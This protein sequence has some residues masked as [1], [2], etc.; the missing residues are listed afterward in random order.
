MAVYLDHNATAPLRAVALEAMQRVLARAAG[1]PS[2]VHRFGRAMRAVIEDARVQVAALAGAAP[3]G[4][5]FTSGGTEAN[6][7][8]ILGSARRRILASAIEHPS[9]LK[10]AD[11]IE[12]VP[13]DADG[14]VDLEV[15]ET[16][17]AARSDPA[18]VSVM[19]ANNETGVLQPVAEVA[20]IAH[21]HGA[22]VHCDAVQAA[23]RLPLDIQAL[24]AD[25]LTL[26]AHKLGGPP[27]VGAV[28]ISGGAGPTAV[29]RGGAQERGL[30]AGTE[31]VPGIAGFGAAAAAAAA[32]VGDRGESRRLTALRDRLEAGVR[33]LCPAA[34]ILGGAVPRLPNT[35]CVTMPGVAGETQV[36][37]FDLEG[38]AVSAGA[39]CSSGKIGR[40]HV[41][42]AMGV[43]PADAASAIRVSLGWTTGD[44]DVERFLA[45]WRQ[46]D[47]RAA[48]GRRMAS[49]A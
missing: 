18:L 7:L 37:A 44:G 27:G 13:V 5:V 48:A 24:G 2:S 1:N 40:S 23:G 43:D 6:T 49:A 32:A 41:L 4:V 36:I 20:R 19:F 15:L 29:L 26:S 45:V 31:N 9:V 8:A 47:E 17:L 16:M 28:L 12:T 21:R 46:I 3:A 35:T 14:V 22:I 42:A 30:R 38:V 11:R 33:R 34:R 39:A 25:L 10:A